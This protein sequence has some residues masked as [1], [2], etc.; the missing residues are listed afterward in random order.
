MAF[1]LFA[2]LLCGVGIGAKI[3]SRLL[4]DVFNIHPTLTSGLILLGSVSFMMGLFAHVVFKRHAYTERELMKRIKK[5][6]DLKE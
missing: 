5:L 6:R 2:A 1:G 3:I 4:P